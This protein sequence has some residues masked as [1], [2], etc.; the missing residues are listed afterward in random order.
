MAFVSRFLLPPPPEPSA[1]PLPTEAASQAPQPGA[2]GRL[3]FAVAS[4]KIN[5]QGPRAGG[6]A[7]MGGTGAPP[8]VGGRFVRANIPI[9]VLI[10]QAYGPLQRFEI[11]GVPE[12]AAETR[13]DVEARADGNPTPADMNQMLQALLADRFGLVVRRETREQPVY[14][15]V[16]ARAG[17]LGPRL[18]PHSDNSGCADPQTAQNNVRALDP[19]APLPPPPCGAFRGAPGIGRLAGADVPLDLLGRA[20]SGQ[21][22]RMVVDRTGLAGTFDFVLEWTPL[23]QLPGVDP[24]A[25]NNPDRPSIFT[26][27]EEQLGLKLEA[28]TGPVNMLVVERVEMPTEN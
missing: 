26:A 21:L 2:P 7:P 8:S 28:Q 5:R 13:V 25:I 18:N 24:V 11:A 3:T 23:Q 6:A 27:I 10:A 19:N 15:L 12:W 4:V 9:D 14:A 1:I 20:L 22:G 17:G 16:V